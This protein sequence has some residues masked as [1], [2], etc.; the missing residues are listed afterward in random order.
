MMLEKVKE[1]APIIFENAGPPCENCPEPDF[2]CELR[3][4]FKKKR[5]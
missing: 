2:P 4:N 5:R 1:V 3:N